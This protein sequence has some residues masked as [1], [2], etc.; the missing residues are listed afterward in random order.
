MYA[1]IEFDTTDFKNKED[2]L[3]AFRQVEEMKWMIFNKMPLSNIFSEKELDRYGDP[4]ALFKYLRGN[5]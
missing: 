1:K 5:E 4:D 3:D 2:F